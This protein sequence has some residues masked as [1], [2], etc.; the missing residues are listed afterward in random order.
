[1]SKFK[2][3]AFKPIFNYQTQKNHSIEG[4]KALNSYYEDVIDAEEN[5]DK[6]SLVLYYEETHPELK[7]WNFRIG[8]ID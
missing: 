6:V 3:I 7:G 1:M 4:L 2:L 8:K 5:A